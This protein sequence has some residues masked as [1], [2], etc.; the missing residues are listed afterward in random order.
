ML[1]SENNIAEFLKKV[2]GIKSETV[3]V[4][5]PS[6]K[7]EIKA[8]SLNLKQ[9]KEII[10]S[11]ADGVAGAIALTRIVNNIILDT[12]GDSTLKVY[13]RAPIAVA[14]RSNALGPK[15]KVTEQNVVDLEKLISNYKNYNHNV[16]DNVTVEHGGIKV[17]LTIPTL[18]EE[19]TLIKR[20]EE[21]IKRNG[22]KNNTKN[23]GSIYLYEII[24]Y[25]SSITLDEIVLDYKML[26]IQQKIEIIEGLPLALNKKI[27]NFIED[28]RKAEKDLLTLDDVTLEID[29]DFFDAE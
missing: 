6:R 27:I 22:E 1:M 19:S 14:L 4:F 26:K 13:D 17:Y 20:L 3:T 16:E 18:E 21:E 23:L 10:A 12:T 25:I 8:R 9:Q 24:K 11:S 29:V 2:E 28:L 5:L 15:Y 7:K